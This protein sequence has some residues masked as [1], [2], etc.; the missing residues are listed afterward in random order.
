[1]VKRLKVLPMTPKVH[2]V[3][4]TLKLLMVN[5]SLKLPKNPSRAC[6]DELY[7]ATNGVGSLPAIEIYVHTL[8]NLSTIIRKVNFS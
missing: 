7:A 1:M 6:L 5:S 8:C 2:I 4:D 3:T